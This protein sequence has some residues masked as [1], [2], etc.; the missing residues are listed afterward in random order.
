MSSVSQKLTALALA[1]GGF[2]FSGIATY[3]VLESMEASS[4]SV[5]QEQTAAIV[6][7]TAT[8]QEVPPAPNT[9][10]N[11]VHSKFTAE[12]IAQ[13]EELALKHRDAVFVVTTDEGSQGSG[14][15]IAPDVFITNHHVV[16]RYDGQGPTT[17]EIRT[18][19]GR[20]IS[21][22]YITGDPYVDI[23]ALRLS[24]PITDIEPLVWSSTAPAMGETLMY[25]GNP[26][27]VGAWFVGIGSA[28][29]REFG[30]LL[31]DLPIASGASGS[32][33]LN[34]RG[35]VVS[36]AS[37]IFDLPEL[38]EIDGVFVHEVLPATQVVNSGGAEVDAILGVI[39]G[40]Y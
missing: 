8:V 38:A 23:A 19:D 28:T 6:D 30:V 2:A 39:G 32:P 36:V 4:S 22:T 10:Y 11:P 16:D 31:T 27:I 13:V 18:R 26:A 20:R 3:A 35:E 14:F 29:G 40:A 1:I 25:V 33:I 12:Q 7:E 37:G 5:V 9:T 24:E 15:L 34:M 17:A 21:A